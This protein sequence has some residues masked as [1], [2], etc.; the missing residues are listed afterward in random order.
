MKTIINTENI[1]TFIQQIPT[2]TNNLQNISQTM[3][4]FV[5]CLKQN[6]LT[7]TTQE[8]YQE[9]YER[10]EGILKKEGELDKLEMTMKKRDEVT[11]KSKETIGMLKEIIS[12]IEKITKEGEH[13]EET[14]KKAH[15]ELID[16]IIEARRKEM[17]EKIKE[18]KKEIKEI[19]DDFKRRK[20]EFDKNRKE[21]ENEKNERLEKEYVNEEKMIKEKYERKMKEF[22]EKWEKVG[23]VSI[24]KELEGIIERE[25]MKQLRIYE[26]KENIMIK[27]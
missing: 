8:T 11:N 23:F 27:Q 7:P 16:E 3:K 18:K 15:N 17:E 2:L 4:G 22:E 12:T 24:P 1:Q 9:E 5:D 21:D 20:E 13:N 25:E 6:K 19:K 14:L 26:K 10:K